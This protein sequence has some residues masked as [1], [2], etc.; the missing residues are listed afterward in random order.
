MRP[1]FPSLNVGKPFQRGTVLV[2]PLYLAQFDLFDRFAAKPPWFVADSKL[3]QTALACNRRADGPRLPSLTNPSGGP[4]LFL[5]ED[6]LTELLVLNCSVLVQR[7][8]TIRIPSLCYA[9]APVGRVLGSPV[10]PGPGSTG[11]VACARRQHRLDLFG[12]RDAARVGGRRRLSLHG[13]CPNSTREDVDA[14]VAQLFRLQWQRQIG[15]A[16]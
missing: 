16:G 14:L 11:W 6:R 13:P 7:R 9:S 12:H 2:F 8:A 1:Q 4:A 10:I 3:K 5:P 15:R